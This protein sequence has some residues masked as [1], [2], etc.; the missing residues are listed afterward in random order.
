[1]KI[2]TTYK[3]NNERP[4]F[5]LKEFQDDK[6]VFQRVLKTQGKKKKKKTIINN[7]PTATV[8]VMSEKDFQRLKK[9][10]EELNA[11]VMLIKEKHISIKKVI[12]KF[13]EI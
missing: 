7:L 4:L 5:K 6:I 12:F 2:T 3:E 13:L 9:I 8:H 10:E 11:K 1:M